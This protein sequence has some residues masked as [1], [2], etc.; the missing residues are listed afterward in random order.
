MPGPALEEPGP[1]I[2]RQATLRLLPTTPQQHRQRGQRQQG[3]ESAFPTALRRRGGDRGNG[4]KVVV[5]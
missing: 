2:D 1:L 3:D 4:T 5:L